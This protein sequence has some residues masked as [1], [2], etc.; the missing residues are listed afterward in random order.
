MRHLLVILILIIPLISYSNELKNPA[1][2]ESGTDQNA[3]T[4][5]A[6]NGSPGKQISAI[7]NKNDQSSGIQKSGW[8]LDSVFGA[9]YNYDGMY[10]KAN[11]YYKFPLIKDPGILWESTEVNIGLQEY[12]T[13]AFQRSSV[14]LK[15]TPIAFFDISAYAGY[16]YICKEPAGGMKIV[17]AP[18]SDY[19]EE[20]LDKIDGK[21]KGG[22]RMS[23]I[24]ALKFAFH[25]I[26]AM[27]SLKVEYHDY[28]SDE[29]Y[30]DYE[31]SLIHKGRDTGFEH[32]AALAYLLKPFNNCDTLA[33]AV[34]LTDYHV[35]S[36]GDNSSTLMAAVE[37]N[38]TWPG[39]TENIESNLGLAGGTFLHDRY[40]KGNP[41]FA[42]KFGVQFKFN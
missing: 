24:P 35:N 17:D 42:L 41:T 32:N 16:D 13:P 6:T 14:F 40:E 12:I 28:N 39:F 23:V 8:N 5:P 19:D 37:Y 15:I 34:I 36:T 20:A 26:A 4:A 7:N 1:L 9:R 31:T 33:I 22:F 27:Y 38:F 18:D 29:Y 2:R 11:I 30:Y 25:N 3:K 21:A 10:L